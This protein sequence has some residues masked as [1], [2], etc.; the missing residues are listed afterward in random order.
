MQISEG[1]EVVLCLVRSFPER[2]VCVRA[3]AGDVVLCS[4][5]RHFTLIVSFYTMV[6]K[7]VPANLMLGLTLRWTNIPYRGGRNTPSCF[8]LQEPR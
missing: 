3:L 8:T 5:A 7:S 4:W 6:Y 1:S 2:A